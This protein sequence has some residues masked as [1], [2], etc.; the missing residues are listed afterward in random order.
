MPAEWEP[1]AATWLAWPH[2]VET[3][4]DNLD[5]VQ[6]IYLRLITI[7]QRHETVY[8]FVNDTATAFATVINSGTITADGCSIAPLTSVAANFSYQTTDPLTNALTGSPDTPASIPGANTAQSFVFAFTP[9]SP[10]SPTDV[11]LTFD[12][13]RSRIFDGQEVTAT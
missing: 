11:Q 12:W 3:W 5:E 13:Y 1:H 9:T 4:P 7:L 6:A 10:F 8:L 2:N